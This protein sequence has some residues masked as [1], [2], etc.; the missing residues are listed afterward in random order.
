MLAQLPLDQHVSVVV[1][2][3]EFYVLASE[4]KEASPGDLQ[5]IWDRR[6]NTE[7]TNPDG[8]TDDRHAADSD[9]AFL[10]EALSHIN[11]RIDVLRDAYPFE[12]SSSGE[13]LKVRSEFSR[14]NIIYLFCLLLSNA[15]R[16]EIFKLEERTY[17][18]NNR[19]RDLFQACSAWA[20]AGNVDGS[21]ISFGFPRPDGTNFLTALTNCYRLFGE[22][23]VRN[24]PLA[25]VSSNPKDEG[26]DIIAWGHR[27]DGAPGVQYLLGQAASGD[28]WPGKSV[29]EFIK[30]F[31]DLWFSLSPAS[32]ATPA[33]FI[34]HCIVPTEGTH[35]DRID[36]LTRRFGRVLYRFVIPILA[37]KGFE[38]AEARK[39]V[40]VHRLEDYAE[41]ETW[42]T[43]TVDN[44]LPA[45]RS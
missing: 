44:F 3:F 34:P 31:H 35:Q 15:N 24:A 6:R 32:I 21:A 26:I 19:I 29:V 18:L 43:H 1:D 39:E 25:G 30:P 23:T 36:V 27:N 28:N 2:W 9:E 4:F 22:G 33:L 5:R 14:G 41:I 16:E 40:T 45:G 17:E 11:E 10:Q 38:I 12:F 13:L 37:D 42:V 7:E 20:A 8:T